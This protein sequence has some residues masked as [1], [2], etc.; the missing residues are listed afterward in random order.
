[1]SFDE[2]IINMGLNPDRSD[3]II[4]AAEIFLKTFLSGRVRQKFMSQEWD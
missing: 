4:P 3:V 2:R 1:M